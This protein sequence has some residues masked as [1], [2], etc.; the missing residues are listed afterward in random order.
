MNSRYWQALA[1]AAVGVATVVWSILN[2]GDLSLVGLFIG[3]A[4]LPTAV[5]L[6]SAGQLHQPI[7]GGSLLG[8][9]TIGPLV[10]VL[11]HGFV[12][13]FAYFLFLGFAEE[14]TKILEAFRIDPALVEVAGSPW[15]LL[16][17]FELV[18]VAPLTEEVGKGLGGWLSRPTSRQ[19]AFMAGIAAGVGFAA[20][21]NILYASGGFFFGSDW[22]AVVAG[23]PGGATSVPVVRADGGRGT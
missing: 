9:A 4:S 20:V 18:L 2:P 12:F 6:F 11:S 14:A 5:L 23:V 17:L 19:A 7:P 16:L 15:T 10:A 1:A 21:E 22:Q 13:G 8:G 3:A